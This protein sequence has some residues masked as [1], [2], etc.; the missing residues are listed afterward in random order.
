MTLTKPVEAEDRIDQSANCHLLSAPSNMFKCPLV[1]LAQ[2]N[3]FTYLLPILSM[4]YSLD[5]LFEIVQNCLP[6]RALRFF[7]ILI[8]WLK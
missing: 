7:R 1:R 3:R 2:H 6:P 5:V 4:D 8:F